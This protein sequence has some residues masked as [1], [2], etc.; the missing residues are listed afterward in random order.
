MDPVISTSQIELALREMP[1][2][3]VL[4]SGLGLL[5]DSQRIGHIF[6]IVVAVD[7]SQLI[8]GVGERS[9]AYGRQH[10][11]ILETALREH[12]LS[13]DEWMDSSHRARPGKEIRGLEVVNNSGIITCSG[14]SLL[15]GGLEDRAVLNLA[16]LLSAHLHFD[17]VSLD[18]KILPE[19]KLV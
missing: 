2:E 19:A 16:N 3:G 17:H 18:Q 5:N 9:G 13:P 8:V 4:F 7:A 11:Q 12:Q 10:W 14:A 15:Y 1:Q 6:K